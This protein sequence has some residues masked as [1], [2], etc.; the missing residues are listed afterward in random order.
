MRV[1]FAPDYRAGNP[2]QSLLA[3]ALG[4]LGVEVDYPRGYRRL[5]PFGRSVRQ[6]KADLV[7]LH[8]PEAYFPPGSPLQSYL[9]RLRYPLDFGLAAISAPV[10]FTAH[11]LLP[12]QGG[13]WIDR[14]NVHTCFRFAKGIIAHSAES[15][16]A[17]RRFEPGLRSQLAVIPHGDLAAAFPP[18][19]DRIAARSHLGIAAEEPVVLMFG[20]AEPYKGI[21]EVLRVWPELHANARLWIAGTPYTATYG[22]QLTALAVNKPRLTLELTWQDDAA[23][24]VRIAAADAVLFNYTRIFTSGAACL[25]RSLGVPILLPQRSH[26]VDL[27]EPARSVFRFESVKSGLASALQAALGTSPDPASAADWRRRTAWDEIA[28]QTRDVYQ[29]V[30]S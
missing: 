10:V 19:P 12:H 7:H 8:W 25:A 2:Y 26:T 16:N 21:E 14:I 6:S 5:L 1:L 15:A 18:L 27:A 28:R 17:I 29:S 23:L 30:L 22:E 11:N 13:D 4:R 24:A 9:R 3:A 20:R